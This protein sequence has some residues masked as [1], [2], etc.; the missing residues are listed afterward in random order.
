MFNIIKMKKFEILRELPKC[1]TE[2]RSGHMLLEKWRRYILLQRRV[3]TNL[4]FVKYAIS[5][6]SIVIIIKYGRPRQSGVGKASAYE[7]WRDT[8]T[9]YIGV[10]IKGLY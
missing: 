3:A 5:T 6:P 8:F 1:D 2:T 10:G 4:Q 9:L 7:I